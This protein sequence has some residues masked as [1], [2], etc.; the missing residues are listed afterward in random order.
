[1]F[2]QKGITKAFFFMI[3]MNTASALAFLVLYFSVHLVMMLWVS[4]IFLTAAVLMTGF[5]LFMRRRYPKL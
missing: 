2:Q 4:F 1:M 3:I 5:M